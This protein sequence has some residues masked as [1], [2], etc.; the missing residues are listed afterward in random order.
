MPCHMLSECDALRSGA[1]SCSCN[2]NNNDDKNNS[3]NDDSDDSDDDDRWS[4]DDDDKS[5][6]DA[7]AIIRGDRVRFDVDNFNLKHQRAS[8]RVD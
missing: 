3:N 1:H 8:T 6:N 5:I 4:D 2:S 7:N